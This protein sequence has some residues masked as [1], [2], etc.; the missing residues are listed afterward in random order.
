MADLRS[1]VEREKCAERKLE[2]VQDVCKVLFD[3][4]S[5]RTGTL[6]ELLIVLMI[7]FDRFLT[8]TLTSIIRL[9]HASILF[10]CL[11]LVLFALPLARHHEISRWLQ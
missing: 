3:E 9:R 10:T 1:L 6:P 5:T 7:A 4:V 2:L 11:C 8:L